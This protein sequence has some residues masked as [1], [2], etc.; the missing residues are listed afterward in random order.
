[1]S[2]PSLSPEA[3]TEVKWRAA[4][5]RSKRRGPI[6]ILAH[7]YQWLALIYWWKGAVKARIYAGPSQW[8]ETLF[9]G[10][11]PVSEAAAWVVSQWGLPEAYAGLPRY[12]G[13]LGS[14]LP[15]DPDLVHREG[16]RVWFSRLRDNLPPFLVKPVCDVLRGLRY[17]TVRAQKKTWEQAY[18]EDAPMLLDLIYEG[19]RKNGDPCCNGFRA[20][21]VG[22]RSGL[23]RFRQDRTCCG[24]EEWEVTL[25]IFPFRRKYL[26]GFNYGH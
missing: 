25:G 24:S 6:W 2:L 26:L 16:Y 3:L 18:P 17:Q 13:T 8:E 14:A 20:T 5:V 10:K 21:K 7:K 22:H 1:M 11:D 15:C 12:I 19:V 23:R 4:T 9:Q